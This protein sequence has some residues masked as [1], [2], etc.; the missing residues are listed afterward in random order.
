MSFIVVAQQIWSHFSNIFITNLAILYFHL[1]SI[2]NNWIPFDCA[3]NQK[4]GMP[5]LLFRIH[6]IVFL[7]C[8]LP[9]RPNPHRLMTL[10][11]GAL[12]EL[13]G[14]VHHLFAQAFPMPLGRFLLLIYVRSLLP[15]G[16]LIFLRDTDLPRSTTFL[17][18]FFAIVFLTLL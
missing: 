12:Y 16:F 3:L 18:F 11:E 4:V 2:C 5:T 14:L 13:R 6:I 8:S 10:V 1:L 17:R 9:K 7:G 15:L